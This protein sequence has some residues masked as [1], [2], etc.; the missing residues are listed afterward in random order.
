MNIWNVFPVV[1]GF[2]WQF[3]SVAGSRFKPEGFLR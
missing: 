1:R 3:R 2:P